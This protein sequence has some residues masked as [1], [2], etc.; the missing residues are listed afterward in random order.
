[1]SAGTTVPLDCD[2]DPTSQNSCEAEIRAGQPI[3]AKLYPTAMCNSGCVYALAGG[4]VRLIPPWVTLGIH[5]VGIDVVTSKILN[6]TRAPVYQ[7]H[8]QHVLRAVASR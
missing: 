1:V 8:C 5:D 2:R 7:R 3:E 4:V 6:P